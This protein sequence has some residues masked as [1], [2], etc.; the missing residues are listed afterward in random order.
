[1]TD[2]ERVF[3]VLNGKTRIWRFTPEEQSGSSD[4]ADRLLWL[5][6]LRAEHELAAALFGRVSEGTDASARKPPAPYRFLRDLAQPI[7]TDFNALLQEIGRYE[8]RGQE[9][10]VCDSGDGFVNK[11]R[12]MR[13]SI[14]TGYLAPLANIV[15]HNRLFPEER[16]TLE[17]IYV[18]GERHYMVLRQKRVEILLD[19]SGYPVKPTADQI[20]SAI[21]ARSVKLMEYV[22]SSDG[23]DSSE[24]SDSGDSGERLRFYNADYY[25]SDLQPGRNTVL[26]ADTGKVRFV[27]P[28]IT[29]N[30]PDGPLTPVSR[31]GVRREDLPGQIFEDDERG[32]LRWTTVVPET[33]TTFGMRASQLHD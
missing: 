21:A 23:D 17:N 6:I 27:D 9:S 24:S 14:L 20:R 2:E 32:W 4:A 25:I 15:Y 3:E 11:L 22:G 13:P 26:D 28:R 30:D 8:D 29:L 19:E 16:Y 33:E 10:I 7:P 18:S 31:L 5:G 1:M 12:P